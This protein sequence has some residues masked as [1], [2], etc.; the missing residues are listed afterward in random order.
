MNIENDFLTDFD[1][2]GKEPE[3]YY[4][5]KSK[6]SST[7]GIVLTVI[8][9]IIYIAFLIYKL[10]RMVR[11]V[12][13]T[14]YDSY[15][16]NGLPS[17]KL[18]NNEF[19]GGFGMGGIVDEQMYYLNVTYVSKEKVNGVW[20]DHV[21][22]LQTEIC[23]LD[24]FGP[25]YK[26]IFSDQ[27][28]HN[29][30]CI[31]DVSGMVLEGYANLERFSYFNVKYYPCVGETKDG[32]PCYDYMKKAK[33]FASNVI[34]LKIQDNDLNPTDYKFPVIRRQKDM[35]SPVFKDL[36]Q[37]IYSYLQI[38]NIET[39]EDIT[40][41]NFFTDS[42]RREQYMKYENSFLIATPLASNDL[43]YG[44]ILLTGKPVADV[45]L[46]LH[47]K[48]LTQKRQYTQLIDVLG[49]VGGLMEILLTFLN[50]ISSFITEVLYDKALV[51]D[52]FSFDLDKK[53]VL[54]NPK[55][56]SSQTNKDNT[57]KNLIKIDN[58]NPTPTPI[59]N[60]KMLEEHN[61][62]DI[63]SKEN[64]EEQKT[65]SK[66]N[67]ITIARKKIKKKK[68]SNR[69]FRNST[70]DIMIQSKE[71]NINNEKVHNVENKLSFEENKNIISVDNKANDPMV[72]EI[73]T[74]QDNNV[75]IETK[76]R[77]VYIN[78]WLICFFWCSSRKKNVNKILFE[79]GSRILTQR[80]DI[81]N[82]FNHFYVIEI[83]QKK[84][85]I[86]LKDMN[87]SDICKYGLQ[88]IN[89]NNN[90]KTIEN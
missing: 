72:Y 56:K 18:T 9:I 82:M 65:I 60:N 36:Y 23:Q 67:D 50:I 8:Y 3:L 12:D 34:E 66:N 79:E 68:K 2:F 88:I 59:Q 74:I 58:P 30:Y 80:L 25:A 14:F 85:G 70:K 76:L 27:P 62:I 13:V 35:N 24:W 26:E 77:N 73:G 53:L 47:A 51:N 52:L 7:L 31:R 64:L 19:Y 11:R 38:V 81:L 39:D 86:D 63:Y 87:M 1:L 29:Y 45:T 78:N 46:Q 48:V 61:D 75:P 17:I 4:K 55:Y 89:A 21:T 57:S 71:H 22:E 41:L 37:L 40:G 44:D 84:M 69:S 5:G 16:F 83:M 90:Y 10:I 42:I 43:Y 28:L 15:T 32:R 54:F 49:D 33:F 20:V 6:K